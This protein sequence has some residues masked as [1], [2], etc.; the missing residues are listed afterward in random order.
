MSETILEYVTRLADQ[1]SL[2]EKQMLVERLTESRKQDKPSSH[3]HVSLRGTWQNSFPEDFDVDRTLY[4]IR[5]EWE[6][7]W[8]EVFNK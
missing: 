6:K 3:I 1:L 4:E 7:E 8:P 5:H 2:E